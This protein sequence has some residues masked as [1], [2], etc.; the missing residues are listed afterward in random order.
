[1]PVHCRPPL[2]KFKQVT[3]VSIIIPALNEAATIEAVVSFCL[4]EPFVSEVIVVDD[5]SRDRTAFLA[6]KAGARVIVS[7]QRGKGISM[8]DGIV[9]ATEDVLVFLDA[10]IHPYPANTIRNL[11]QPVVDGSFDFVKGAFARNA[12]RVTELVAKPLLKIFFPELSS[13]QQP[14]S[15]MIAGKRKLFEKL[16][17]FVDYGVDVGILIDMFLMQARMTEVNIG[18]IENKSKPWQELGKMSGEVSRAIIH[19]AAVRQ[20]NFINLDELGIVNSITAG[21]KSAIKQEMNALQKIVVFDMDNTLLR[22]RFIDVC[23]E[24]FL[25]TDELAQLRATEKSPVILTKQVAKLM[26]GISLGDILQVIAAIPMVEDAESVVAAL[27]HKGIVVGIISDSYQVVADFVRNKIGADF[28]IA[29]RLEFFSGKATGE[30]TIPSVFYN[31]ETST[32]S[33]TVCKS[34]AL[35]HAARQYGQPLENCIAIGDSLNDLCMIEHAGLGIAFCT[36]EPELRAVADEMIDRP[37]FV[38][39]LKMEGGYTRRKLQTVF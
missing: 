39:L 28:A 31:D 10:D 16:D 12:G 29:N 3:M 18:Y 26:K 32:C 19:K 7:G 9:N 37:A 17:F 24:K 21:M 6:E 13:F 36:P 33:H 5:N 14:L 11:A 8:R 25:F 27:K 22:G 1:M 34:N 23:A 20:S 4:R 35:R 38:D 30:V 2:T 15:G